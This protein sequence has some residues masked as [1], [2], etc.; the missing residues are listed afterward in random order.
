MQPLDRLADLF[1][2]ENALCS[3]HS[4][5]SNQTNESTDFA[6]F[7]RLGREDK[8]FRFKARTAEVEEQTPFDN[9][10]L[11]F[12][13]RFHYY[14]DCENRLLDVNDA[15]EARVASYAYDYRGR[16]ISR[17]IYATPNATI[18]YA[19]DGDRIL[20]EYDGSGTLLRKFVYG[21]GLD[22]PICL[23][24]AGNGN[25]AYYYHLDGLGSVVALSDVNNVLVERYAY[26]VFGRP[27]IRD[28]NGGVVAESAWGNPYLF[29]ARAYD[30]ESGLYYYRARYYDYATGRFLQPDPIGYSDGLN[31]YTYVGNNPSN[32]VDP[33]GLCKE[34]SE[35]SLAE[36]IPGIGRIPPEHRKPFLDWLEQMKKKPQVGRRP[37]DH[38]GPEGLWDKYQEW[39]EDEKPRGSKTKA[40]KPW[41]K[42]AFDAVQTV[43]A[44]VTSSAAAVGQAAAAAGEWAYEHPAQ[45]TTIVVGAGIIVFD[46]VTVPSGEGTLGVLMIQKAVSP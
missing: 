34:N 3:F 19:Y 42:M 12:D 33:S 22:E 32:W 28:P 26:D 16:R 11:A 45:A 44:G 37:N 38:Y 1:G 43:A 9:G 35:E 41:Q 8:A 13:G 2:N 46:I 25:A 30:A 31:L 23:I 6:D 7:R 15:A 40:K 21:P 27:T 18:R 10:N 14:Y 5:P 36:L 4:Q 20:A 29:T 39:L 24:D 17:T